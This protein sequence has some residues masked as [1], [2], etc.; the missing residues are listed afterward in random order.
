MYP[1]EAEQ[2]ECCTLNEIT[3]TKQH[4]LHSF[5][6][7]NPLQVYL[8]TAIK[9]RMYKKSELE[10]TRTSCWQTLVFNWY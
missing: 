9:K 2:E 3:D 7:L 5:S 10:K 8:P 4:I 6:S 1:I